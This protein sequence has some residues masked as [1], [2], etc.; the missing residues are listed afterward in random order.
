M[1]GIFWGSG[2]EQWLCKG[3]E[4]WGRFD[5]GGWVILLQQPGGPCRDSALAVNE[6]PCIKHVLVVWEWLATNLDPGI[7]AAFN[8]QVKSLGV[9]FT[10]NFIEVAGTRWYGC[11]TKNRGKT[12]KMDGENNGKPYEQMDDLGGVP[13]IF[14]LTPICF[15]IAFLRHCQLSWRARNDPGNVLAGDFSPGVLYEGLE[16]QILKDDSSVPGSKLPLFPY[17]RGWS[18]TQ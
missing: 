4:C 15:Q 13:P 8:D 11:W 7:H 18:S 5:R 10:N 3:A 16:S 14:G 12:T 9:F 17:N 6:S 2:T 1:I